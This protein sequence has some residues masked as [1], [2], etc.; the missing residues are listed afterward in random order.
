MSRVRCKAI[1]ARLGASKRGDVVGFR[2]FRDNGQSWF[3]AVIWRDQ[4][5]AV[6]PGLGGMN[7]FAVGINARGDV[8]GLSETGQ[9]DPLGNPV[10]RA[11]VWRN[12]NV[13]DL[14]TLG[15][16]NSVAYG[17]DNAGTIAGTAE[18][19]AVDPRRGQAITRACLWERSVTR[20]LG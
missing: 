11:V 13:Q 18:T 3:Q 4:D 17:I 20:D 5:V 1:P 15:G 7:S 14:G 2:Y 8:V 9:E 16:R 6:L 19:G 12:G 10:S